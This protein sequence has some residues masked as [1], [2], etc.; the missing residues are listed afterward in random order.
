V[1]ASLSNLISELRG[2]L[3]EHAADVTFIRTVHGVGY[4]FAAEA[5]GIEARPP[6]TLA[7]PASGTRCWLVH[8]DRPTVLPAGDHVIG[9]D[10]ACAV[11]ID[12]EGV[13]RRHA[14][15]HVPADPDAAVTIE[16]LASTNGTFVEGRPIDDRSP[17][18]NGVRIRMGRATLI[19]REQD[20]GRAKTRR[21]KPASSRS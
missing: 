9:R 21:V 18:K 6:G 10:A 3:A 5:H 7:A 13:S 16:D 2:V 4:A 20:E 17:L 1:D 12:V 11:W 8:K 14:S 19:F 15:I